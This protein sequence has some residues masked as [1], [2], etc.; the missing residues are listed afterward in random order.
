[1]IEVMFVCLGNICRSP[2]AEAI[3]KHKLKEKGLENQVR[4]TSSGTGNWH[5]GKRPHEG[6]LE[7]LDMHGI[8]HE[9]M[10]GSQ[11]KSEDFRTFDY[12]I[13]LDSSNEANLLRI[14]P[15]DAKAK[16]IRLLSF[17]KQFNDH[18]VPDPYFTGNFREVY[19][20]IDE[21]VERF[22]LEITE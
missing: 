21:A 3:M 9:G 19:E 2:M 22:I 17:S 7:I 8:D 10:T 15:D 14:R 11:V 4:V 13:A 20:M 5:I 12:L 6:T 16:I 18:D 1:M